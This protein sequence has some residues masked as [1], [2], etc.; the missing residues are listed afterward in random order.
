MS[1]RKE[2][3]LGLS[4]YVPLEGNILSIRTNG[5]A[6]SPAAK[7]HAVFQFLSHLEHGFLFWLFVFPVLFL[8]P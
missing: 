7:N 4:F 1:E 2:S 3:D 6:Y 8:V 5:S